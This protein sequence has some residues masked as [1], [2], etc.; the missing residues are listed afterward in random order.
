MSFYVPTPRTS[1]R[2]KLG[3]ALAGGGF[4]ASLFHLGVLRRMA[5]L[6]LLRYVEV[7]STVSGGSIIGALYVLML[8]Q[9]LDRRPKLSRGE[10]VE[11]I[12]ELERTFVCGVQK[13]L[14]TRLFMNPLGMLSV[15]LSHDGLSRR[16]GRIYQR[17][18]YSSAVDAVRQQDPT[19]P[20]G[21]WVGRRLWRVSR[22]LWPGWISLHCLQFKP[23]G[24][25]L[26]RGLEDYNRDKLAELEP[27]SAVPNLILNSTALNSAAPFRFSSIE[28]GDPR[29]GFFRYDE[30]EILEARKDLLHRSTA[31]LRAMLTNPSLRPQVR[32]TA[33]DPRA[34]ALALWWLARNTK[35]PALSD[36]GQWTWVF[37]DSP[38]VTNVIDSMCKTNF[39]RLRQLKLA[40]WYVRIGLWHEVGGGGPPEQHLARFNRVLCEVE[41]TVSDQITAAIA[42][43]D[44]LGSELLDFALELYYLRSAEVMSPRLCKDFGKISLGTAVAASANFP[45][46]FSPLVL[47]GIYDDLHVSRLGLSDGG[48]YDNLGITTLLDEG[49]THIIASDTGAPFSVR[50]RVSSRYLGMLMRL[51][52]VLTDDVAEQQRTQ[53]RERQRVSEGLRKSSGNDQAMK[54][55]KDQYGLKGLAFFTID[56]VNPRGG[57]GISL[58]FDPEAV[59]CLRTDLDS[60]GDMEVAAL[61]NTGYDRADRFLRTYFTQPPYSA[62]KNPGWNSKPTPPCFISPPDEARVSHVLEVGQSRF[63]RALSLYSTSAWVFTFAL[64]AIVLYVLGNPRLSVQTMVNGISGWILDRLG[65][66]IP[67]HPDLCIN[68]AA[69]S[70]VMTPRSLW[71][72]LAAAAVIGSIVF[73]LWPR[74]T[75][76]LR[77]TRMARSRAVVTVVKWARAFAPALFLLAGLA[78]IWISAIAFVIAAIS[79]YAYNKPFLWATRM[80]AG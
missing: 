57:G 20:R 6:D 34:V 44:A 56:S 72:F 53:L 71:T 19:L 61:I 45:P 63:F 11:L 21:G 38:Q 24:Q 68:R 25:R 13:D 43:R 32:G 15:L 74:L 39:G 48:V 41:P 8:K 78:P 26:A 2:D 58:G 55:L 64:I 47:L 65:T 49:C 4:R 1:A 69:R 60:F 7:L 17:Y 40:A 62:A 42:N 66:P 75:R 46:V 37:S 18:L 30:I 54:N 12:K 22:L 59:A 27:G 77:Q 9:Q 70:L 67:R 23:G 10:Y 16:M 33:L 5:E 79:Y 3:L 36:L 28:I 51:P 50:Q 35:Q 29:L 31:E 52:E 80:R 76:R 14:R 73:I